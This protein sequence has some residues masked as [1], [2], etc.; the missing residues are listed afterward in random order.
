MPLNRFVVVG[1]VLVAVGAVLPFLI[2]FALRA[3]DVHLN[4]GLRT[5]LASFW[6]LSVAMHVGKVQRQEWHDDQ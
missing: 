4:S 3:V 6:Q 2:V 1:F 5:S